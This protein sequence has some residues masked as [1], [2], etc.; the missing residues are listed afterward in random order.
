MAEMGTPLNHQGF[1]FL[2]LALLTLAHGLYPQG[3]LP[4]QDGGW[5]FN[6]Y[7]QVPGRNPEAGRK[8]KEDHAQLVVAPFYEAFLGIPLTYT[9]VS[10]LSSMVLPSCKQVALFCF[11]LKPGRSQLK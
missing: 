4:V 5:H 9:L 10:Q 8:A 3:Y 2:F 6:C 1:R 7:G 11:V